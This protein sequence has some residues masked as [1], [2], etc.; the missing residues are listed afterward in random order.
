MKTNHPF[1]KPLLALL[2]LFMTVSCTES[3]DPLPQEDATLIQESIVVNAAFE[4]ADN[5]ALTAFQTQ[6]PG[7]RSVLGLKSDLCS[8]A[9]VEV[10]PENKS[11]QIDFGTGC[12]SASGIERKGKLI[13]SYAE[14]TEQGF[15]ISTT[16][17]D[18]HVNGLKIEGMRKLFYRGFNSNGNYFSFESVIYDGKVTWPDGKFATI[19]GEFP[20]KLFLPNDNEGIKLEVT[21]GAG[22]TNRLGMNYF[23]TIEK[24]LTFFQECTEKG[25]WIPSMG[26]IE[27]TI[28]E[29]NKF[30]VDYGEGTCDKDAIVNHNGAS[31]PIKFD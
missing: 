4:E 9:K 30:T 21:G 2:V 6:G 19:E 29:S 8:T 1:L 27:I 7:F 11:I 13:I 12:K 14:S 10:F 31:F 20:K 25:N 16:F 15:V 17:S 28:A 5:F 23:Y 26:I 22:G 18:Y 3:V 24:P